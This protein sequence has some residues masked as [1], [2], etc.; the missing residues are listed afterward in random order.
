MFGPEYLLYEKLLFQGW[1]LA[2]TSP[3]GRGGKVRLHYRNWGRCIIGILLRG[4]LS[5]GRNIIIGNG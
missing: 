3:R 1:S 2:T 4:S 5:G